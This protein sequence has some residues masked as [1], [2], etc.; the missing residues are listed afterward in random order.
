MDRKENQKNSPGNMW[1]L[2]RKSAAIS[3]NQEKGN[4]KIQ[5][6]N[7]MRSQILKTEVCRIFSIYLFSL[8][9]KVA[10]QNNHQLLEN[11][12]HLHENTDFFFNISHK[13]FSY[14]LNICLFA[15]KYI[16]NT[17]SVM[18]CISIVFLFVPHRNWTIFAKK[19]IPCQ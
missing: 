15:L 2:E 18:Y 12:H 1:D 10:C 9:F 4:C 14:Y 19:T 5:R 11:K 13:I 17:Y 6:E 8:G 3:R 16:I 7:M